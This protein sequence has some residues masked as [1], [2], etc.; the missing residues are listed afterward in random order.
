MALV[1]G[2]CPRCE[3]EV[4]LEGDSKF[5]FCMYCGGRITVEQA[6]ELYQASGG[7]QEAKKRTAKQDDALMEARAALSHNHF[8]LAE[9]LFKEIHENDS[10]DL[11]AQWGM[12]LAKTHNLTPS[13]IRNPDDFAHSEASDLFTKGGAGID[14]EWSVSYWEA[15]EDA[16]KMSVEQIDPRVFLELKIYQWYPSSNTFLYPISKDFDI[17]PILD[18]ELWTDWN[19][20]MEA[21]PADNRGEFREMC[22]N[23]C[24]RIREYFQSGFANMAEIQ[25]GDLSRLMGTWQLKLTTGAQKTEVLSFTQNA[26]GVPHLESYR[27]TVNGYD[28]YRFI[29]VDQSNRVIAGEHRHFPSSTGL[30]GDF[31]VP[32][33]NTPVLGLMAVYEYILILPTALYSRTE[34]HKIPNHGRALVFI[35]KCRTMPCF[36]RS[37]NLKHAY[38]MRPIGDNHESG[39][40]SKKMRSC[41]IATAVYGDIDAPQVHRLRRFRDESLNQSRLGRRLCTL[42]YAVSPRLARR[43]SPN[44]PV[45]RFIRRA[46]DAFVRRLGD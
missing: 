37:E 13:A 46:L 22:D 18:K 41:Y 5:S 35:E 29:S 7:H 28:Y 39:D 25:N 38:Q 16:C 27:T 40:A 2:K 26:V 1:T 20:L 24:R 3:K 34:P 17:Q 8:D 32:E 9:K 14:K 4:Q 23:C 45:S 31:A 11:Q 21:L 42:Y 10:D 44:G 19:K 43:F 12:I 6:V 36:F 33:A 30:G 15:F